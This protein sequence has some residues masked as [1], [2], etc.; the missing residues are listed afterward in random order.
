MDTDKT[1][2]IGDSESSD[3]IGAKNAN[4]DSILF[5]KN[6]NEEKKDTTAKYVIEKLDDIFKI[7]E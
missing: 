1:I 2:M 3:I 4:I 6:P 5:V 7:I